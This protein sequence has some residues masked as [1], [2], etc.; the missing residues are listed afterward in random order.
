MRHLAASFCSLAIRRAL[1]SDVS[2][3]AKLKSRLNSHHRL[4]DLWPPEGGSRQQQL[5]HYKMLLH[6]SGTRLFVA[7]RSSHGIVGYITAIVQARKCNEKDFRRVGVIGEVFVEKRYRNC[8]IGSALVDAAI[9]FF[10]KRGIRHITL[11]NAVG[12]ELAN[13]FWCSLT[14]N[15]VLY[16]RTTTLADLDRA[17]RRARKHWR[18]SP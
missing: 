17:L 9:R 2:S 18:V 10:S 8:G 11:R 7:E 3:I 1:A 13:R 4:L 16:T 15:P 14:F 5:T 12:N 6:Q